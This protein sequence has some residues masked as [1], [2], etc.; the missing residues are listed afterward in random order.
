MILEKMS[1]VSL[2][3]LKVCG[4]S[5]NFEFLLGTIASAIR[6]PR[7]SNNITVQA[8]RVLRVNKKRF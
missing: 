6:N 7:H 8:R 1:I 5:M 4:N 3:L 2:S